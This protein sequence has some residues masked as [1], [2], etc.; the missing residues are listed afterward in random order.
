MRFMS[1]NNRTQFV[2]AKDVTNARID[3][4]ILKRGDRDPR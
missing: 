4:N 1:I 3:N 2:N